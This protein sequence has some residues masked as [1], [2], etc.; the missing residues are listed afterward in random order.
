MDDEDVVIYVFRC[1]PLFLD[2]VGSIKWSGLLSNGRCCCHYTADIGA[3]LARPGGL[4]SASVRP[5]T[6]DL[7]FLC[8]SGRWGQHAAP[9][10][11]TSMRRAL[12]WA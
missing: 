12:S 3:T 1:F 8:Q 10:R 5:G 9:G 4:A 11:E 2:Q 6:R 7:T